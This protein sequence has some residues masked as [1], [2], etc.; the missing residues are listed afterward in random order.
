[1]KPLRRKQIDSFRPVIDRNY[2]EEF[3]STVSLHCNIS[4]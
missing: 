3:F 2:G 4:M 1:V